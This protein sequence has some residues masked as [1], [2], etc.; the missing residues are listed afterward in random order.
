MSLREFDAS[1]GDAPRLAG[2][3]CSTGPP[4]EDDVEAWICTAAIGWLNDIPR[5]RFQRRSIG[6]VEDGD[7]LFAVVAWQD[8]ARVDVDGIWLEVLAVNVT[9]Q[10]GGHGARAYDTTADH[11][12]TV[13][14]NGNNLAG[15]VHVD[16]RRSQRLL[17]A[18]WRTVA[19]WDDHELWV[20]QL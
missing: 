14:R 15:L 19:T 16:N 5:A 8:V 18:G 6:L 2:F 11:L 17:T 9:R 20:G 10:H 13:D 12:R 1:G 3:S 7:E 4:Y